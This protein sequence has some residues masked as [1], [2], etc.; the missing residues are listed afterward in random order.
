MTTFS[1]P[2]KVLYDAI[3]TVVSLEVANGSVYTGTLSQLEDN[4]NVLLTKAQKTSKSGRVENMASVLVRGSHIVFFQL[5]DA[6]RAGPALLK[7][8]TIVP[9]ALDARGEGKGFGERRTVKRGR[10]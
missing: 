9:S 1:V 10:A 3:G 5:P 2:L 7:A 4:M 6:L 8:G